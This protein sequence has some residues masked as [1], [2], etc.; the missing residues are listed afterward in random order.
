MKEKVEKI[1]LDS[2]KEFNGEADKDKVLEISKDTVL[3]D[4]DGKIDSLDFVALIVIIETNILDKLDKD[5]TIVNEKAFSGEYN[6]FKNVNT[7]IEFILEILES[8][9]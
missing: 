6:P 7:L 8:G 5:I 4:I 3:L 2:L 1:V 9:E